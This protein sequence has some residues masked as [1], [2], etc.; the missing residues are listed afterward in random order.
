MNLIAC[1]PP[2]SVNKDAHSGFETQRRCHQESKTGV[3][4]APQKGLMSS[5]FFEKSIALLSLQLQ[6]FLF[7]EIL[8]CGNM[9][10]NLSGSLSLHPLE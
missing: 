7:Q 4:V 8:P 1:M 2:P 5:I 10:S 6:F 9:L 3:S